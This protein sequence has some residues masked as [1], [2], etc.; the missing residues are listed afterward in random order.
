MF[1]KDKRSS[2]FYPFVIG[3]EEKLASTPAALTFSGII[4]TAISVLPKI[5][6]QVTLL[7]A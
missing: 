4:Y 3:D 1:A 6:T 7:G 5:L 2:L